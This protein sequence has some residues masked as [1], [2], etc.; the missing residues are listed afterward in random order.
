[1]KKAILLV[2]ALLFAVGVAFTGDG[3]HKFVGTKKCKMCHQ[4]AKKGE[5]FEKWAASAHAKAYHTLGEA[6]AK[7]IY[8]KLGKEG[9][10]Q[11]DPACLKCHVAGY[12]LDS[13]L[14]VKVV[15]ENGVT[16]ES[17]HGAG[18]DYWKKSVMVDHDASVA[19]GMVADPKAGCV[20]CHNEEAPTF[21]GFDFEERWK[22][23][24]HAKPAG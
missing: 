7:E 23:I 21:K 22:E 14:T 8:T 20:K 19:A 6:A 11:E 1:M 16:C 13:T 24:K 17:C 12:G 4:K 2:V 15:K 5:I 3:A 9:N 10:P 18:G